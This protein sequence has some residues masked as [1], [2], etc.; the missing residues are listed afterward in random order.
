[1]ALAF[2]LDEHLRGPLWNAIERHNGDSELVID[3]IRVG[4]PAD[5][6]L[7]SDDP[8]ILQWAEREGRI[9]LTEDKHTMPVHLDEHLQAGRHSPGVFILRMGS[10]WSELLEC[11]ELVGH[12][13]EEAEYR[14]AVTFVP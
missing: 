7:G 12:V 2:L 6:P 4:D 8:T 3:I 9:V 13:G 5:V 11:L 14:D 10:T 1:M